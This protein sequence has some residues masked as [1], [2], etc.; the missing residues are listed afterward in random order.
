MSSWDVLDWTT[1]GKKGG[2]WRAP[3][4]VRGLT[5]GSNKCAW[6]VTG[7]RNLVGAHKGRALYPEVLIRGGF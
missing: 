6:G 3:S 7:D 2:K 1:P 4:V 5:G